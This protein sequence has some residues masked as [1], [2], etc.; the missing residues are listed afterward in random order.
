MVFG[1]FRSSFY[2]SDSDWVPMVIDDQLQGDFK[3][4]IWNPVLEFV[5]QCN[6]HYKQVHR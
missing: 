5:T 4:L 3:L 1:R 6:L 2:L